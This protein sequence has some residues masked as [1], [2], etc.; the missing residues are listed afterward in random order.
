LIDLD[1]AGAGPP[2]TDLASALARATRD[3]VVGRISEAE[4][5]AVQSGLLDAYSAVARLP[6][7]QS[8][9]WHTAACLV[10]EG[11]LRA[12]NR[13]RVDAIPH[14]GEILRRAISLAE[15]ARD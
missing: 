8:L 1:Q 15:G 11:G 4:H 7:A 10:A 9:R 2:E 5:G 14:V 13:V 6:D 12:V 3:L